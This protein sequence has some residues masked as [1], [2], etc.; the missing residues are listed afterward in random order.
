MYKLNWNKSMIMINISS[1]T[2]VKK[3][4]NRQLYFEWKFKLK[5]R[6]NHGL[7]PK[8]EHFVSNSQKMSGE[9]HLLF[10]PSFTP[11]SV[12]GYAWISLNIPKYPWECLH[13]VLIM[14]GTWRCLIIL[15]VRQAFKDVLVFKCVRVLNI[16]QLYMQEL[17]RVFEYCLSNAW[18]CLSMP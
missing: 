11:V 13:N 9:V 18:I 14:T 8:S 4:A 6:I 5:D 10:P 12:D 3:Y 17:Y 16:A 15:H 2:Q 7:F 1:K